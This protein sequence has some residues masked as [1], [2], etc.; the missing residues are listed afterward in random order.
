[1]TRQGIYALLLALA[2]GALEMSI[3]HAIPI[4]KPAPEF[5]AGSWINSNPLKAQDLKGRVVMVEFWTY[6]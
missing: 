6:G 2:I 1:M 3:A 4:G 5:S